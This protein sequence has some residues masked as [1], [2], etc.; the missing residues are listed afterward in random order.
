MFDS[1]SPDPAIAAGR[2][3]KLQDLIADLEALRAPAE[4]AFMAIGA[5]LTTALDLLNGLDSRF[6]ALAGRLDGD[7]AENAVRFLGRAEERCGQLGGE[8]A[9][10]LALLRNLDEAAQA[11]DLPLTALGKVADEIGALAINAKIQ[12]AQ[13]LAADTDFSVFTTEI[14]RLGNMSGQAIGTAADRLDKLRGAIA[15]AA[16]AEEQFDRTDARELDS[17][18]GRLESCLAALADRKRDSATAVAAVSRKTRQIAERVTTCITALQINDMTNQRVEHVRQALELLGTILAPDAGLVAGGEW[19]RQLDE[20]HKDALVAAV[21]RLQAQQLARAAD[22]F[23]REVDS[24]KRNMAA[25]A[26]DAEEILQ[27]ALAALGGGSDRSFVQELEENVDRASV[28]LKSYASAETRIQGLVGTVSQGFAAM[29][30]DLAAIHS[31]DADMRIMGL[32]ASL[33]CSRLGNAGKALGVVAQELRACSRRA[34]ETT[35]AISHHVVS[36]MKASEELAKTSRDDHDGAA[37]LATAMATSVDALRALG[38]ELDDALVRL[39]GDCGRASSL[40]SETATGIAIGGELRAATGQASAILSGIAEAIHVPPSV[41]AGIHDD[42]KRLLDNHYTMASERMIHAL[43]AEGS[44]SE[45]P[46]AQA[47]HRADSADIEDC[48]F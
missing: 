7:V 6:A 22:D 34:E 43:F 45:T 4:P 14:A 11:T 48:L 3:G 46:A 44:A 42:V 16:A 8:T 32:N 13:V 17:V 28:L 18:R 37:G 5:T 39:R 30:D 23:V 10:A 36:A 1:P 29:A 25:L 12:A 21:C 33:K 24:L 20:P 15:A 26:A 35:E 27:E 41:A 2:A 47:P 9:R 40:L 19:V 31:I 38:Q